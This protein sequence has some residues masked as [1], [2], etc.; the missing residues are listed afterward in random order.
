MKSVTSGDRASPG[1]DIETV[2]LT[3]EL[4]SQ[5]AT[6]LAH[7]RFPGGWSTPERQ[8]CETALTR[9]LKFE[10][11]RFLLAGQGE[12]FL[13]FTALSWGFSTTK[14][15]PILYVQDLFTLPEYRRRGV[16]TALLHRAIAIA[17][18]GGA[19]RLQLLTDGENVSARALYA[20][21]GFEWFPRKAVYMLYL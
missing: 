18:E 5:A 6:L 7:Y 1:G 9:L 13:G 3:S 10:S 17:R 19:H 11:V 8:E 16:A 12:A 15:Q 2:D 4:L 20:S 14:G 21:R